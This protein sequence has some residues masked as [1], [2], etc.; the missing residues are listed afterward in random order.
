MQDLEMS[1]RNR[2]KPSAAPPPSA[3]AHHHRVLMIAYAFPPAGGSG[4][5]RSAKF[6][7]YLPEFGWRPTVWS[8]R[9]P[10]DLPCDE[11]LLADLPPTLDHRVRTRWDVAGRP[12]QCARIADAWVRRLSRHADW[13][14][15]VAWRVQRG[16]AAA[17]KHLPPDETVCW[18]LGSYAPLCN[19]IRREKIDAIYSTFSPASNHLLAWMLA[20]ATRRP[21]VADFRDLWT[22]EYRYRFA[23]G[24]QWRRALDR[25]LER[26]FL[27]DADAVLAVTSSQTHALAKR[28]GRDQSK[29]ITVTNGLDTDDFTTGCDS[30]HASATQPD[31]GRP[32][33]DR[34]VLTYV[35]RFTSESVSTSLMEGLERFAEHKPDCA[36]TFQL[37]HVGQCSSDMRQRLDAGP[38][39]WITLGYRPHPQA[40]AEMKSADVLLLALADHPVAATILTGKLFEY[41][42][43]GRPILIVGPTHSEAAD[44]IRRCRAGVICTPTPQD[45]CDTLQRLWNAW[46]QGRLPPGCTPDKLQPFTRRHLTARL[47]ATLDAV[48]KRRPSPATPGRADRPAPRNHRQPA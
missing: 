36:K 21:W 20:R 2:V 48:R 3:Q 44:L 9:C 11:S 38:V 13:G 1:D 45:V 34:F 7:K 35:G 8:T 29:F 23:A 31:S 27:L 33:R 30:H 46:S 16:L 12:L 17:V 4:V 25:S 37:R 40:V 42:A 26:R 6:A 28:T 32:P 47:A 10:P 43:S 22:D 19:L 41:L 14:T 15:N 5:Q 39:P 18:A 24:P